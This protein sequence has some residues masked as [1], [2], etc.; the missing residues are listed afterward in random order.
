MNLCKHNA[1]AAEYNED[2]RTCNFIKETF[3]NNLPIINKYHCIKN[4]SGYCAW[5]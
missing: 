4:I 1:I 5:N 2:S 3:S